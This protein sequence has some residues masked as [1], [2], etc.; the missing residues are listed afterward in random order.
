MLAFVFTFC[1][2]IYIYIYIYI[3]VCMY[4]YIHNTYI[5]SYSATLQLVNSCVGDISSATG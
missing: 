4:I 3:Y 2:F 5:L 1:V